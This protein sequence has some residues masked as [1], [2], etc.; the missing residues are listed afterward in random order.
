[1]LNSLEDVIPAFPAANMR[2]LKSAGTVYITLTT[3]LCTCVSLETFETCT[4]SGAFLASHF[5]HFIFKRRSWTWLSG[6]DSE[7]I[8][9]LLQ[10][11]ANMSPL[12][13]IHVKPFFFFLLV[14]CIQWLGRCERQTRSSGGVQRGT[15]VKS[16][17]A[18]LTGTLH[19]YMVRNR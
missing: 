4:S 8:R 11:V 13:S 9:L 16:S 10:T 14:H 7:K 2:P 6:S 18:G 5:Q 1:M 17:P 3:C 19:F 15:G 12:S